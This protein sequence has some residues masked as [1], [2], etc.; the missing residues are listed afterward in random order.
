MKF[1]YISLQDICPAFLFV[2]RTRNQLYDLAYFST[3][4]FDAYAK[5][6]NGF[7]V[8]ERPIVAQKLTDLFVD[9]IAPI[10]L[11]EN[12]LGKFKENYVL[13]KRDHAIT[14]M[15]KYNTEVPNDECV[16]I[17]DS[18]INELHAFEKVEFD[19]DI[20]DNAPR[21]IESKKVQISEPSIDKQLAK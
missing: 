5:D 3:D 19:K 11:N 10:K 2:P 1:P 17:V 15:H 18:A 13:K 21:D 8:E 12:K 6:D 4:G 9:M 20:F 14:V 7:T 16:K